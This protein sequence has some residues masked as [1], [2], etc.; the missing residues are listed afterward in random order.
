MARE[1]LR[2]LGSFCILPHH[3]FSGFSIQKF[4]VLMMLKGI[5]FFAA[6]S[7]KDLEYL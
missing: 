5:I 4:G 1:R 3:H 2:Q 7:S 6:K